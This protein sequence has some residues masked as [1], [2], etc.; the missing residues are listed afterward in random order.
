MT[1]GRKVRTRQRKAGR[2]PKRDPKALIA[3]PSFAPLL[4]VWGALLGGLAVMVMPGTLIE[5]ATRSTLLATF[6][7]PLQAT[8][9][10]ALALVLGAVLFVPAAV[11]SAEVRRRMNPFSVVDSI[12]RR[13]SP[14][15]PVRDLGTKSLD[16]PIETMPFATPA[17]RD[18]EVAEPHRVPEP[19]PK[20]ESEPEQQPLP[21][22]MRQPP[23]EPA[24][25]QVP[26]P[27][28][29]VEPAIVAEAPLASAPQAL[30]LAE[31]AELPGRNAVWVEEAPVPLPPVQQAAAATTFVPLREAPAPEPRRPAPPPPPAPG[32]AALAR[33]RATPASE[34]SMVEMIERFAG[35]LHEHRTAQ[36][37]RALT[38]DELAAREAA[39]GE[40]LKALA[41]LSGAGAPPRPVTG[42]EPL[43]A[44]LTQLHPRRG[45]A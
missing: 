23:A 21:R 14:I 12:V 39:L 16:D 41:A 18:A 19:E 37:A 4:G 8:L 34:L 1:S 6:D 26:E 40:A 9:A 29:E 10:G 3:H 38:A 24:P 42:D 31:F 5:T 30:D 13:V 45:A 43:R 35:A 44:A 36:P 11:K 20:L 7:V 2:A 32:T 15:D 22:F 25:S 27:A 28:R 17:W 33:L